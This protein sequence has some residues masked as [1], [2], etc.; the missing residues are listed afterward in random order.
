M[1]M[2]LA[3]VLAVLAGTMPAAAEDMRAD[4]ARRFVAGKQFAYNCFEGTSGHGRI[5][6]DGSVAGYIQIGGAGW[7]A[8][9]R[10]VCA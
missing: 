9:R 8:R 5:Y 2:R 6:A 3:V 4:E 1:S 10:G 7:P